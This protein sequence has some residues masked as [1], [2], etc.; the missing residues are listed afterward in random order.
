MSGIAV[1][2]AVGAAACFAVASALQ[3]QAAA[4]EHGY[5]N[6]IRLVW[7]LA[8]NRRWATGL[9]IATV[10]LIL[11]AAA[12]TTGALAVVQPVLTMSVAL[13]LPVRA[14]LDRDRPPAGQVLAAA[15]LAA[16]VA[17]FATA[18]HPRNGQSVP[19]A[20]GAALVIAA[21]VALA[22]ICSVIASRARSG[23][24][25][26]LTLGLA[27]GTLYGLV[28]GALK[29]ATHAGLRD[30]VD[31][32]TGWPLW[33]LA[34]LGAW[35]VIVHQRAYTHGPLA[36][37]LPAL[38]VANPL[39]GTV[40]GMLVFGETPANAPLA[41]LGEALGLAVIVVAVTMLARAPAGGGHRREDGGAGDRQAHDR[42]LRLPG[43]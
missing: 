18:A 32:L 33:T 19:D 29:A 15:V 7:R 5:R 26:G 37:S 35:A 43:G 20:R 31:A 1:G 24:V 10:G 25:A 8:R 14:L 40:F 9:A 12:L 11:H 27:A 39:T 21:G 3:H 36:V 28:G 16:G 4:G 17:V 6:G 38:S 41:L 13:A 23:R 22:G 34:V 30:P 2:F 42:Q